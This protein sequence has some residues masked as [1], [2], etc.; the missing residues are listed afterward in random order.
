MAATTASIV[1]VFFCE[2]RM[3][4][5]ALCLSL[6]TTCLAIYRLALRELE[7]SRR[8]GG[9][10]RW[11]MDQPWIVGPQNKSKCKQGEEIFKKRPLN[12]ATNRMSTVAA[13]FGLGEKWSGERQDETKQSGLEEIVLTLYLGP[14]VCRDRFSA[15]RSLTVCLT[16]TPWYTLLEY[17]RQSRKTVWE[18]TFDTNPETVWLVAGNTTSYKFSSIPTNVC[19]FECFTVLFI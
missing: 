9:R 18:S 19:S 1:S 12:C 13:L 2:V 8:R 10:C 4:L 11:S 14:F 17:S 15:S 6:H 5:C 16:R 7:G 3:G